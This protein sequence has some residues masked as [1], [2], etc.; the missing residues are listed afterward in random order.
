M[1]PTFRPGE[2]LGAMTRV[3]NPDGSPIDTT[4]PRQATWGELEGRRLAEEAACFL[5]DHVAGFESSFLSDTAVQLGVRETRHVVGDYTLTGD[6]VTSGARFDD[7]VTACA[8][9]QE[10]HVGG[11]STEY[12]FL[13]PSTTYQIP[14][15][16]LRPQGVANLVVAGRCISADHHALASARVMA[17][18][19]AMGQAAGLAA[20]LASRDAGGDLNA[21]EVSELQD[22]LLA[23]GAKL[24]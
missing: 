6:D 21:I 24:D 11:R 15:R 19:L 13:E 4:D 3:A 8:W 17:P 9:P 14:F 12:R 23:L 1:I 18:C 10:Y 2:F 7:A 22:G 16:S 20:H 5:V